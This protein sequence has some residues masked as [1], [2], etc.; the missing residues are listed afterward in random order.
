MIERQYQNWPDL[1]AFEGQ[2][3]LIA[4]GAQMLRAASEFDRLVG[5]GRSGADAV[6][7]LRREEH[8]YYPG[9]LAAVEN[10]LDE[11]LK[12]CGDNEVPDENC[13]ISPEQLVYRPIAEEV[14]RSLRS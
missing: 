6:S 2:T 4:I 5:V 9:L 8:E 3:R 14:L 7:I 11:L 13:G 10:N 12:G 1:D